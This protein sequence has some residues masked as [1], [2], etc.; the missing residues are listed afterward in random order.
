MWTKPS[1]TS[2][3]GDLEEEE[4]EDFS[5][6]QAKRVRFEKPN[7]ESIIPTKEELEFLRNSPVPEG[8]YDPYE[9]LKLQ[10][11][12][13]GIKDRKKRL[14]YLGELDIDTLRYNRNETYNK[15]RALEE[16]F[17]TGFEALLAGYT[18]PFED[19]REQFASTGWNRIA[20]VSVDGGKRIERIRCLCQIP[21][22]FE[23]Q[24]YYVLKK[25]EADM[26]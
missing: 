12:R 26:E 23:E 17:L 13:N 15:I 8:L 10:F 14:L 2:N 20:N 18:D 6:N 5:H 16:G 4:P 3:K 19:L 22:I 9:D 25:C 24:A 1:R 11:N 7:K 21:R